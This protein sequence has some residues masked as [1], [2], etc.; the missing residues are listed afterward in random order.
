MA[1]FISRGGAVVRGAV[2]HI[3]QLIE[4][5]THIFSV[6][7]VPQTVDALVVCPGLGARTL[8]GVEDKTVYPS[9]G[10]VVLI[11]APWITTAM[12]AS[13]FEGTVWTYVIPRR[14]GDVALGGTKVANDWY[15]L[16]R[17]ETTEDILLRCL[18]L[19]PE[20]AP[21]EI[22]AQRAPTVDDI[23]SLIIEVGCG[24]RPARTGGIRLDVEWTTSRRDDK[25]V[26]VVFNY[27]HAGAG[28]ESSWGSASIA[29]DL[30]EEALLV[31]PGM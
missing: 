26:P 2:Q 19:C 6:S 18:A 1:R 9:R 21:P 25:K 8:G 17:P 12:R 15:P 13:D 30:L 24:F 23:R 3:S 28:F 11:R 27:G 20:L 7:R 16:A 14:N 22:R 10:Q 5:G 31:G 29:V 4:G